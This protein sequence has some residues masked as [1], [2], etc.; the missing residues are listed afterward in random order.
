MVAGL[1]SDSIGLV[2]TLAHHTTSHIH[3]HRRCI[4]SSCLA[5]TKLLA[6][7]VTNID[8]IGVHR[9]VTRSR[10]LNER[11]IQEL[12]FAPAKISRYM[13]VD[14]ALVLAAYCHQFHPFYFMLFN[15]IAKQHPAPYSITSFFSIPF[16]GLAN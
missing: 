7:S 16:Q 1:N 5:S 15:L 14:T 13:V 11:Q 3:R 10:R 4:A 6:I 9:W 2:G 8:S 12:K